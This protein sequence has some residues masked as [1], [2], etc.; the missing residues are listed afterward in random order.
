MTTGN[1]R[2]LLAA[3]ISHLMFEIVHPFYDGTG[4]TGRYLLGI[5][6]AIRSPRP[7]P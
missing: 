4:R 1:P 7:P 3:F 6:L 5:H 2:N